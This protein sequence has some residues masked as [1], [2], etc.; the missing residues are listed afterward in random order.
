MIPSP[1]RW[2]QSPATPPWLLAA[3]AL[4]LQMAPGLALFDGGLVRSTIVGKL[5]MMT[6][7]ALVASTVNWTLVASSLDVGT[8]S[9]AA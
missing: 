7:C 9:A 1:S 4:V 3:S 8:T 6:F 5:M 2:R